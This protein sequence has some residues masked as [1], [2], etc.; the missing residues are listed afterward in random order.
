MPRE[1]RFGAR[2]AGSPPR[3]ASPDSARLPNEVADA[4]V[5]RAAIDWPALL[6]RVE[7]STNRA[8]FEN[9]RIVDRFR[10]PRSADGPIVKSGPPYLLIV[11]LML[12]LAALQTVCGLAA[13]GVAI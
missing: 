5:D 3:C 6:T 12:A 2:S 13:V 7:S 4:F 8:L 11:R 10:Q 9:L 1:W